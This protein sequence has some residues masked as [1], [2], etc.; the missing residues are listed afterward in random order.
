MLIGEM[1]HFIDL[2]QY[3][4]GE[5]PERVHAQALSMQR[6]DVADRDNVTLIITFDRGSVGTL[7]YNTV[8]DKAASKERLE[9][10]GGGVVAIVDDF[11]ILEVT[12]GG[13]RSRSKSL[14]QDKGQR[15]QIASTVEHFLHHGTSPIPFEE[16]LLGMQVVF[17]ARKSLSSG[18][19]IDL[20]SHHLAEDI[21]A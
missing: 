10:Y 4:T 3:V 13:K 20:A 11:R 19:P 2:M 8:G 12:Q 21:P 9:V 7:C 1:C 18:R 6:N 15:R 17:A 5:R 16:L 14:N